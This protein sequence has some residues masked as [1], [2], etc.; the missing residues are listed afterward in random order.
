MGMINKYT[1]G[2][3]VA[4]GVFIGGF[5]L[6]KGQKQV[7][8]QEKIVREKGEKEIVIRD[9]IITVTKI[10]KPD[11]T[12]EETTKTEDKQSAE[13]SKSSSTEKD[14]VVVS[15]PILSKYS[16][17]LKYWADVTDKLDEGKLK[18]KNKYEITA[19]YRMIG[20]VWGTIGYKLDNSLSLGLSLQF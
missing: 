2:L 20:E 16:L 12:I 11:G 7:E 15:T 6:G 9:K 13:K 8:I 14:K 10:L 5:Y 19:G 3:L 1:V 4:I 17:G 18:D